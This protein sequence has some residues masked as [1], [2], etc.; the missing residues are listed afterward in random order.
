EVKRGSIYQGIIL[1]PPAY[2]RGPAGEKWLLE[3]NINEL[4]KLCG[5]LLDK[6]DHFFIINL[7]S[8]GFSA[9]ILDNLVAGS[10]GKVK[11]PEFGELFF[12]DQF[13]KKLPLGVFYR[14]S[15]T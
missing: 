8:M 3:D 1:D 15:N 6:N 10:F 14:F 12:E 5:E 13:N 11:N 7:Y 4:I 2:G 9:L